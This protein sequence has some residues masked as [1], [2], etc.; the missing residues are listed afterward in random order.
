MTRT[1]GRLAQLL[2]AA[3]RREAPDEAMMQRLRSAT[4]SAWQA[5][6]ARRRRQRRLAVAA[7]LLLLAAAGVL[8]ARF[9]DQEPAM[10]VARDIRGQPVRVGQPVVA[11][12]GG[13]ALVRLPGATTTLRL[14]AGT[15]IA[16]RSA[17]ELDLVAGSLYMDTGSTGDPLP[18]RLQAGPV[19]IAHVGTQF[20]ARRLADAVQVSVREGRVQLDRGGQQVELVRGDAATVSFRSD[21]PIDRYSAPSS[22][23]RWAWVD[24]LAPPL[25]IEGRNLYA[26][27]QALAY[28]AGLV[29][30][31]DD[32]GVLA[33]TE[34]TVLHGPDLA[35]PPADALQAILATTDL[36]GLVYM[37]GDEVRIGRR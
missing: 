13:L 31:I 28:Q 37:E 2:R 25:A 33:R 29:L 1:S 26:V 5:G 3:G 16:W 9:H 12:A 11:P 32:P 22:G 21:A 6:L 15:R 23:A 36:A 24:A 14:A 27:L 18:L 7:S 10:M 19:S 20:L 30:R 17:S 8:L 34:T 35:L 4:H